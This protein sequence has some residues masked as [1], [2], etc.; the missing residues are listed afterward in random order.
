M[1]SQAGLAYSLQ[2][3]GFILAGALTGLVL[4]LMLLVR[5]FLDRS[6]VA[7]S[8]A[9]LVLIAAAAIAL[10]AASP[11]DSAV[12]SDRLEILELALISASGPLAV[13]IAAGL[14]RQ[15]LRVEAAIG[16]AAAG[17]ATLLLLTQLYGGDPVRR[18]VPL[19]SAFVL[20]G[21]IIARRSAG[22]A[23]RR[24]LAYRRRT[25]AFAVLFALTVSNAASLVRLVLHDVESLRLIVPLTLSLLLVLLAL[26]L[27]WAL[28]KRSS[29]LFDGRREALRADDALV[30]RAAELIDHDGLFRQADLD[31]ETVADML[32]VAPA[33][34]ISALAASE[35]GGFA[36]LVRSI[37]ISQVQRMLRDGG[38]QQTSIDAIGMLC[39]FR[40][41]SVL[42]QAFRMHVGVN[43]GEYRAKSCPDT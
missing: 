2:V 40:S 15:P 19:Q 36:S 18:A 41:R 14:L 17:F 4:G 38:E 32:E 39:G 35:W 42:Y 12:M 5:G 7:S 6:R 28:L 13:L 16:V 23:H 43:P 24:S 3:N 31:V 29:G 10:I 1:R 20:F 21:W 25:I 11:G 33:K 37:R 34:L 30:T 27:L 9:A 22:S 8:L 26:V